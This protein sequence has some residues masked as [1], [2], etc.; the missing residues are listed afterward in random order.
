M[1]I[2]YTILLFL[3]FASTAVMAL[4]MI[5][6]PIPIITI[7]YGSEDNSLLKSTSTITIPEQEMLK[8]TDRELKALITLEGES[9][10]RNVRETEMR[11]DA[12]EKYLSKLN[13]QQDV[14]Y[15]KFISTPGLKSLITENRQTF[16]KLLVL[17]DE[18][19]NLKKS[20]LPEDAKRL[21]QVS[22]QIKSLNNSINI[23]KKEFSLLIDYSNI[24]RM[25]YGINQNR[26]NSIKKQL[27]FIEND[28]RSINEKHR[29][30][31]NKITETLN[32]LES[33]YIYGWSDKNNDCLRYD[34]RDK[35]IDTVDS[36]FCI[37]KVG[38]NFKFVNGDCQQ[39]TT[40]HFLLQDK[41]PA[42]SC[43][44]ANKIVHMWK[45]IDGRIKCYRYSLTE[46]NIGVDSIIIDKD[47]KAKSEDNYF[48][49]K[50]YKPIFFTRKQDDVMYCFKKVP[51]IPKFITF[52]SEQ[53]KDTEFITFNEIYD[54]KNCIKSKDIFLDDLEKYIKEHPENW[55]YQ[56]VLDTSFQ[57]FSNH[58]VD[59]EQT[60]HQAQILRAILLDPKSK[61]KKSVDRKIA[62]R[63]DDH[64]LKKL[65]ENYSTLDKELRCELKNSKKYVPPVLQK[66]FSNFLNDLYRLI[67]EQ[68]KK[69]ESPLE[70][71]TTLTSTF[72]T[73]QPDEV[74]KVLDRII[75]EFIVDSGQFLEFNQ[76]FNHIRAILPDKYAKM[77]CPEYGPKHSICHNLIA[78]AEKALLLRIE[79]EITPLLKSPLDAAIAMRTL[80]EIIKHRLELGS[81]RKEQF[82][83][84]NKK[85]WLMISNIKYYP[86]DNMKCGH[87]K[88]PYSDIF[89]SFFRE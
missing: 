47:T 2:T 73:S 69:K 68:K 64:L 25:Q 46:E 42:L 3:F 1:K 17:Q 9:L 81:E 83:F 35:Y 52:S 33:F 43:Y 28:I 75:E 57:A 22:S 44:K 87:A 82:F 63:S 84:H 8:M 45:N 54:I 49:N 76:R 86:V 48:C 38:T 41:L 26:I 53:I 70:L 31:I 85:C 40:K 88:E 79:K 29:Q 51:A 13:E 62:N 16:I 23:Q 30:Q 7:S 21:S 27:K 55:F 56:E 39:Y 18:E 50:E 14:L 72:K 58:Y 5:Y 37:Q 66:N 34:S 67:I 60:D 24:N 15:K 10:L 19:K 36:S 74:A 59:Q 65:F 11:K 6:H 80:G 77:D 20:K 4:I 32:K 61:F 12:F 71:M 78:K 89:S